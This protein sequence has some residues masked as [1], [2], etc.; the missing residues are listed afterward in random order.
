MRGALTSFAAIAAVLM[1]TGT[2]AAGLRLAGTVL[3]PGAADTAVFEDGAG[4]QAVRRVGDLVAPDLRLVAVRRGLAVVRDGAGRTLTLRAGGSVPR[5]GEGRE[6]AGARASSPAGQTASNAPAGNEGA[7]HPTHVRFGSRLT[8]V[9]A[10][11]RLE[12][13]RLAGGPPD[14]PLVRAGLLPGDLIVSVGGR[15]FDPDD[16]R[17][18]PSLL[19]ALEAADAAAPLLVEARRGDEVIRVAVGN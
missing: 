9:R 14:T 18:V 7:E 4:R 12:G 2:A 3:I 10:G 15:S 8:P 1:L 19:E 11:D 13:L 16:A 17:L 6:P 5:P